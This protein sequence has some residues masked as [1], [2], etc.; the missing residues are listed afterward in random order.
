MKKLFSALLVACMLLSALSLLGVYAASDLT[1][2]EAVKIEIESGTVEG[3]EIRS[4]NCS[5]GGKHIGGMDGGNGSVTITVN[6]PTAGEGTLVMYYFCAQVRKLGL[7]V[8][9]VAQDVIQVADNDTWG[10]NNEGEATAHDA[11][12]ISLKEGENTIKFYGLS[13]ENA[14]NVDYIMVTAPEAE[15]VP[16]TVPAPAPTGDNMIFV[17]ALGA[18]TV[19]GTAVVITRKRS[20]TE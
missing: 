14:P 5:S 10:N 12:T 13:G 11:I 20:I 17:L 18:V 15:V 9:G 3:G 4:S 7:D 8:N 16:D 1:A 19:I 2:G 6:S